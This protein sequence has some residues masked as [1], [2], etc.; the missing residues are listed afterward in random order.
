MRPPHLFSFCRIACGSSYCTAIKMWRNVASLPAYLRWNI[1]TLLTVPG[2]QSLDI[3]GIHNTMYADSSRLFGFGF[4]LDDTIFLL[5]NRSIFIIYIPILRHPQV[6]VVPCQHQTEVSIVNCYLSSVSSKLEISTSYFHYVTSNILL[7][8]FY[9]F[10]NIF[11]NFF[12][13]QDAMILSSPSLNKKNI[14]TFCEVA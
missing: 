9:L 2:E 14:W 3:P 6:Y 10:F 8:N 1:A 5:Y 12:K 11:T 7:A 13:R 4:E